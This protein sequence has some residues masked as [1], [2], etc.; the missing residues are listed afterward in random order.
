M[1][2]FL[3]SKIKINGGDSMKNER[4]YLDVLS[5]ETQRFTKVTEE[6]RKEI[7]R[8]IKKDFDIQV[9]VFP[10]VQMGSIIKYFYCIRE[11]VSAIDYNEIEL[12]YDDNIHNVISTYMRLREN[13]NHVTKYRGIEFSEEEITYV[14]N[15]VS[16]YIIDI[17]NIHTVEDEDYK[18]YLE[19]LDDSTYT[20]MLLIS[21]VRNFDRINDEVGTNKAFINSCYW[22][23]GMWAFLDNDMSCDEVRSLLREL[24]PVEY[25]TI[26]EKM[27]GADI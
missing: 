8:R 4:K 27:L 16:Q 20:D 11:F 5:F 23:I 13:D 6:D 18:R 7:Q 10:V 22:G 15:I 24:E 1:A 3:C 19:S 26:Y 12:L 2:L 14:K 17:D 9:V 25:Y 21:R